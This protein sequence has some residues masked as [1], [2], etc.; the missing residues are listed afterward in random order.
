MPTDAILN[1][2][3]L[4]CFQIFSGYECL[5][6]IKIHLY[7]CCRYRINQQDEDSLLALHKYLT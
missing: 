6:M 4:L 5:C 1:E 3:S 2:K 7:V